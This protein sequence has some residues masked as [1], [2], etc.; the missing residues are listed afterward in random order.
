MSAVAVG[1][2]KAETS[3]FAC[4]SD[5]KAGT[6]PCWVPDPVGMAAAT[7]AP[8]V[9]ALELG[10]VELPA[11]NGAASAPASEPLEVPVPVE[12]AAAEVAAAEVVPLV[13][14]PVPDDP[15]CPSEPFP[16]PKS[17]PN[18][19]SRRPRFLA[20]RRSRSSGGVLEVTHL[21]TGLVLKLSKD[22]RD[23]RRLDEFG[24]LRSR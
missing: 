14:V 13:P 15:S 6:T 24:F 22:R 3:A 17:A 10:F 2:A 23:R 11:G 12:A 18:R 5:P 1:S 16:S 8:L 19:S 20:E 9:A 7:A 4:P 21:S